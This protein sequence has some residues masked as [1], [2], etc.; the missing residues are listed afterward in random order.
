MI[1]PTAR[2]PFMPLVACQMIYVGETVFLYRLFFEWPKPKCVP[3]QYKKKK[4]EMELRSPSFETKINGN[5]GTKA[6]G[7]STWLPRTQTKW[8]QKIREQKHVASFSALDQLSKAGRRC[9][10]VS[11]WMMDAQVLAYNM[12]EQVWTMDMECGSREIHCFANTPFLFSKTE[13]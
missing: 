10:G 7:M 11:F 2:G 8:L 6:I 4:G 12:P 1:I 3:W 13:F 5:G 9:S